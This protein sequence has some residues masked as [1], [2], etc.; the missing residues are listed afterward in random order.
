MKQDVDSFVK[1]CVVC[2]Q[3]KH[4]NTLPSGLLAPLP[5]PEGA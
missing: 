2:Q 1:Q 5:I 4:V 3:A